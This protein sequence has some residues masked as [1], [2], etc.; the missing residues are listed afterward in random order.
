MWMGI[1]TALAAFMLYAKEKNP[2]FPANK[3]LLS[4]GL[5]VLIFVTGHLGGSL[6][7]G[8]DYF[9]KP[10]ADVFG[11]DTTASSV[12]KPIANV[13]E[14]VVYTD[15]AA[16]ILQTKCY[17]CHGAN[18]QKG[19]L[20]LDDS[21]MMMKGG[22]DGVVIKP[23]KGDASELIKRMLLPLND[24]DHMPPKEKPQPTA[25]QIALLHWWIDNGAGFNNKVKQLNQPAN[26][27][28]A[29]LALQKASVPKHEDTDIPVQPVEQ[30]DNKIID[31]LKMHGIVVLPVAQNSHYLIM[32]FVT[33][34]LVSNDVLQLM[35]QLKKQ[36]AWLKINSTNINDSALG[37]IAQLTALTRLDVSH[38]AITDR[39]LQQLQQLQQLHYLNLVGT[40]IT[41]QG[42][43]QLKGLRSLR[44]V[45]LYQ[46][47]INKAAYAALKSS[48][49]KT[50]LDTGG[51]S[52]PTLLTDTT[53][54]KAK[55]QY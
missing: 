6:T 29:L 7:H 38:T 25:D 48:F 15:I 9:T 17:S 19:R 20:R 43:L 53:E 35:V 4:L 52:V 31:A 33:D 22:K 5:F 51:Y 37:F 45:Y 36:L 47:H 16:P 28:T 39:G 1:C 55:Q 10:L 26:V 8:S 42:L 21:V 27:K 18:K 49:P 11:S 30:A 50:Y 40:A 54:V 24:D 46:T 3:A 34:T 41:G 2:Q 44:T 23:G 14:A 32:N 12:I 13:Q